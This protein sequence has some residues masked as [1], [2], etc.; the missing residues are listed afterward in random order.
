MFDLIA[1]VPQAEDFLYPRRRLELLLD[2]VPQ[3][4]VQ[5]HR[6]GTVGIDM[7]VHSLV[8]DMDGECRKEVQHATIFGWHM[9]GI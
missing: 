8:P 2:L 1:N 3:G 5:A 7:E 9:E 6:R 4:R